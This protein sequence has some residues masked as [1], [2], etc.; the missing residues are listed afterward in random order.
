MPDQH[1]AAHVPDAQRADHDEPEQGERGARRLEIAQRHERRGTADDD[2][3]ILEPD[4]ADEQADAACHGGEEIGRDHRDDQ[5]A[6]ARQRQDQ[7]S[8]AG[9]EHAAQRDR[10][11]HAMPCTTVKLK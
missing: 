9:D 3:G 11:G 4:E 8:D 7:E 2:A 1:G 6:H 5:L 10:P